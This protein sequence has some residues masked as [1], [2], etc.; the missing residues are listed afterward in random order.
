[1]TLEISASKYRNNLHLAQHTPV[2]VNPCL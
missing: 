1:M 2:T